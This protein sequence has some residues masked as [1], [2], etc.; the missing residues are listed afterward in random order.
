MERLLTCARPRSGRTVSS[1]PTASIR[2][3][4]PSNRFATAG[5]ATEPALQPPVTAGAAPLGPSFQPPS[6]FKRSPTHAQQSEA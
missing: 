5:T 1:T 2:L 4:L 6:P 3:P